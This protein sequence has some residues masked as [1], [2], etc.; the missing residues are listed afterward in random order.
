MSTGIN[1][2]YANT[3]IASISQSVGYPLVICSILW[4]PTS[5][6]RVRHSTSTSTTTKSMPMLTAVCWV[7]L[8]SLPWPCSI[9]CETRI[10]F[11]LRWMHDECLLFI[12]YH[13]FRSGW[14]RQRQVSQA[15]AGNDQEGGTIY[16]GHAVAGVSAGWTAGNWLTGWVTDRLTQWPTDGLT[17]LADL[18]TLK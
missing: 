2:Q 1:S 10:K 7:S 17:G 8:Y 12:W 16:A 13:D 6:T 3:S 11:M 15:A 9:G 18:M 14:C 5:A 4:R